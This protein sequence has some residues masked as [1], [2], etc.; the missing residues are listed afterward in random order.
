MGRSLTE[1]RSCTQIRR[2]R[3]AFM[4]DLEPVM[5]LFWIVRMGRD[6]WGLS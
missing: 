5:V 4:I 2:Y 3:S 6:A 1:S